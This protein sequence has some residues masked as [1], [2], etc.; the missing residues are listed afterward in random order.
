VEAVAPSI[1][2]AP[3]APSSAELPQRVEWTLPLIG[4][5]GYIVAFITYRFPIGNI[6][7][8]VALVGL[9]L[10]GK[11]L[12]VPATLIWFGLFILWGFLGY[13]FTE[14]P[15]E[16]WKRLIDLI[17]V[18]LIAMVVINTLRSRAQLRFFLIFFL[19]L[20]ATHPARGAIFNFFG[21]YTLDGRALWNASFGNP[22]DLAALTFLPLAI[23]AGL[24]C[25]KTNKW[26][27][28]GALASIVILPVVIFMTQSRGAMF[29]LAIFTVFTF[30]KQ[31][32][33]RNLLGLVLLA[34]AVVVIAPSG[35]WE[36]MSALKEHG[37]EADTSSRQR[38]LI[39]QV[40]GEIIRDHS[41]TGVGVGAY[42]AAHSDRTLGNADF[43]LAGGRKDTHNTYLNVI[44]ETGYPGFIL[45]MGIIISTL[46]TAQIR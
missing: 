5:L 2:G 39:W 44:A 45:F 31:N 37:S 28:F 23:A 3:V 13:T 30:P 24:L 27:R 42:G 25:D 12:R 20:Y 7:M 4:L 34:L 43:A 16:V 8:I 21:G 9:V 40:A 15:T 14:Y 35:V 29:A 41:V 10:A 19:F 32:H 33:V 22:N 46:V 26:I 6:S 18:W 36:R 11:S 17:K 1:S 38:Y